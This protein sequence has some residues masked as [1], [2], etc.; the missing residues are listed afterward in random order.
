MEHRLLLLL[1]VA[2]AAASAASTVALLVRSSKAS[3]RTTTSSSNSIATATTTADSYNFKGA[4]ARLKA[5]R[6]KAWTDHSAKSSALFDQGPVTRG[7]A[8]AH[9]AVVSNNKNGKEA[10]AHIKWTAREVK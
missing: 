5:N 7:I 10:A 8:Y 4:A 3:S 1:L 9:V 6:K 2:A